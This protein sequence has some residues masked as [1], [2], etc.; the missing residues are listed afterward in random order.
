[1]TM[2]KVVMTVKCD[3]PTCGTVKEF[4]KDNPLE[5]EQDQ[6]DPFADCEGWLFS[7]VQDIC[8]DCLKIQQRMMGK[9]E[10]NYI[11]FAPKEEVEKY[12]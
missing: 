2:V 3:G 1:M 12:L 9:S 4:V 11:K 10:W 5:E 6:E 7:G 8:P